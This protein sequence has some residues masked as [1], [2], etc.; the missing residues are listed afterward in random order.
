M[1]PPSQTAT[2]PVAAVIVEKL[3]EWKVDVVFGLVADNDSPLAQAL[4][5]KEDSIRYIAVH[6]ERSAAFIAASYTKCTG[7]LGVCIAATAEAAEQLLNGLAD[8]T[9]EPAPILAITGV[10]DREGPGAPFTIFEQ[11]ITSPIHALTV[12][13][14][15]C[16]SALHSRGV[17]HITVTQQQEPGENQPANRPNRTAPAIW[18]QY[19]AAAICHQIKDDAILAADPGARLIFASNHWHTRTGHQLVIANAPATPGFPFALAAQLAWPNRQCI[20]LVNDDN[21]VTLMDDFSTAVYYQLPVKVIVIKDSLLSIDFTELAASYGMDA[22]A[23][24]QPGDLQSVM[25]Q[26]LATTSP[27]L[28]EVELETSP[29][30]R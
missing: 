24:T 4:L 10:T 12:V 21:A 6:H 17:A 23:C 8:A 29:T 22:Y 2:A 19:L 30:S 3:I 26:A 5:R 9:K 25:R 15:A 13:D 18:P 28:I 14:L 20:A 11:N 16:R 1:Y 7:N 27:A